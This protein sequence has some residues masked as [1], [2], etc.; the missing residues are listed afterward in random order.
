[1]LEERSASLRSKLT[2]K[3]KVDAIFS[4]MY[5]NWKCMIYVFLGWCIFLTQIHS[6]NAAILSVCGY[7]LSWCMVWTHWGN[8]NSYHLVC[9]AYIIQQFLVF[10][11]VIALKVVFL[12]FFFLSFS[13]L[14]ANELLSE[15]AIIICFP[16]W[17]VAIIALCTQM[18]RLV[19]FVLYDIV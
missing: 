7:H 2:P 16:I 19:S 12:F 3:P 10:L 13:F 1:M 11:G 9:C 14:C 6:V 15:C 4:F 8:S 5:C 17:A 18:D